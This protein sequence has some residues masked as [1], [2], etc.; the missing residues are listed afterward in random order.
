MSPIALRSLL[1]V[2]GLPVSTQDAVTSLRKAAPET[3]RTAFAAWIWLSTSVVLAL[4]AWVNG[5][6]PSL[7]A[8]LF[9]IAATPSLAI[10]LLLPALNADWGAAVVLSVWLASVIV[11]VAVT[12]GAA[13]ILTAGFVVVLAQSV[14][15]RRAWVAE[16]GAVVVLAYVGAAAIAANRG[17]L[18]DDLGAWPQMMV[19]AYLAFSAGLIASASEQLSRAR[20][21]RRIAEVAHELRTPLTHIL[22][23]SELI[24][25]QVFGPLHEKY[26]EYA[27]LIRTSGAHLL[28]LSNDMLDLSRIDAGRYAL[29]RE[30]FD[31]RDVV[32]EVVRA[33]EVTARAKAIALSSSAP[34]T[35]LFVNADRRALV[36]ILLNVVGNA[37]KF[38]PENGRVEVHA[39]AE[40]GALVIETIDNG[41]GISVAERTRLGQAYERGESGLGVEGAGLGLSLV[42]ALAA[43]HGG[44][45]NFDAPPAGGAIV[46]VTLPVLATE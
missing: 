35:P 45:L 24:E 2:S 5:L 13:S 31:V 42:R 6:Q 32:R 21:E 11:L 46:R 40:N 26:V 18:T 9:A 30:R 29:T 1:L 33:S 39:F 44:R 17:A 41:P 25:R 37:L 12:G 36:R 14:A 16:A 20:V 28:D 3:V 8:A 19:V 34:E 10:F 27:G 38:T 23:F 4:I 7:A 43:L 22:G 15:V